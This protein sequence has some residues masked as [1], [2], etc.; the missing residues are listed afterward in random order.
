MKL[1]DDYEFEDDAGRLWY[2]QLVQHVLDHAPKCIGEFQVRLTLPAD[3]IWE[4]RTEWE[5]VCSC[6][7]KTGQILG[8]SLGDLAQDYDG[9]LTFV[10][11]LGFSCSSCN[12][13]TEI[14]DTELHGYDGE[15]KARFDGSGAATYRGTGE[16]KVFACE[17][18]GG[19]QFSA[20]AHFQYSHFDIIEDEPE[21]APVAQDFFDFFECTGVCSGCGQEQSIGGYELA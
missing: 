18:C 1:S 12:R 6:G 5:L 17:K 15:C 16:R 2:E 3:S 11:P 14:I 21:L 20:K 9:P 13:L 7:S 8:Y 10:T 4:N 19:G